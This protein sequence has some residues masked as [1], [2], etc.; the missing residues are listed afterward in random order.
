MV[1]YINKSFGIPLAKR[2]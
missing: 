2:E 1:V